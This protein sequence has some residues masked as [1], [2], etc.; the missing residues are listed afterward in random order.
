VIEVRTKIKPEVPNLRIQTVNPSA[1]ALVLWKNRQMAANHTKYDTN[2]L[3]IDGTIPKS[4]E[5]KE[6]AESYNQKK[7]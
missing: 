6:K 1:Q 5:E 7:V 4:P 3:Q 2:L